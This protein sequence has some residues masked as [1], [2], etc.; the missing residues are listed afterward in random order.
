M[1]S[2]PLRIDRSRE[3]FRAGVIS[4]ITRLLDRLASQCGTAFSMIC[5]RRDSAGILRD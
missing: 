3:C 4:L 5:P 2:S 1:P